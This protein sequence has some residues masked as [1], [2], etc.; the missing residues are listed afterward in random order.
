MNDLT[1]TE[2]RRIK[3]LSALLE[4]P[5]RIGDISVGV[6]NIE[7]GEPVHEHKQ[8]MHSWTRN[9]YNLF[10]SSVM[11]LVATDLT[12][13]DDGHLNIKDT[14]GTLRYSATYGIA[15]YSYAA[16]EGIDDYGILVGTGNAAE[17]FEGY[18]MDALVEHSGSLLDA[19]KLFYFAQPDAKVEWDSGNSDYDVTIRRWMN[20]YSGGDII[21]AEVGLAARGHSGTQIY[22][23][24]LVARDVLGSTVTVA[25]G[26]QLRVAYTFDTETIS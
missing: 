14:G 7:T 5:I 9:M 8:Q 25:N 6:Y 23:Y 4:T 18:A 26:E 15:L 24:T 13:F 16:A 20:N 11:M 19:D 2:R 22:L 21:I 10:T 17:S 3:E 12:D 1:I